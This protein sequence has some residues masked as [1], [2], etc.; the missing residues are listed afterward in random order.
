MFFSSSAKTSD[1]IL[2]PGGGKYRLSLNYKEGWILELTAVSQTNTEL[3][4]PGKH[5]G[6]YHGK[7]SKTLHLETQGNFY[8]ATGIKS[9]GFNFVDS[10]IKVIIITSLFSLS[11]MSIWMFWNISWL[12]QENR[13]MIRVQLG[14]FDVCNNFYSH[15]SQMNIFSG[16]NI[17]QESRRAGFV[18]FYF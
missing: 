15:H 7:F 4:V 6:N 8:T 12:V 10:N 3:M 11:G 17:Y 18:S 16:E 2:F 9:K 1:N 14:V 13:V 5:L